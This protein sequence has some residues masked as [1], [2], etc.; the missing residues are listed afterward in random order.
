[1]LE[2]LHKMVVDVQCDT[3]NTSIGGSQTADAAPLSRK[4]ISLSIR[5]PLRGL[6]K[7]EVNIV[8]IYVLLHKPAS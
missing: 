5:K 1:M 8:L 4:V 7:P 2:A 3:L 6:L